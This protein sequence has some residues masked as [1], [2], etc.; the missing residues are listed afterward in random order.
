MTF[1]MLARDASLTTH[2]GT[3][4][5]VRPGSIAILETIIPSEPRVTHPVSRGRG[6]RARNDAPVIQSVA[7]STPLAQRIRGSLPS[8]SPGERKVALQVLT[9]YT[10]AAFAT[11][12]DLA[13]TAGTSGP[14]VMRF[15]T[16]LGFPG[17]RDFQHELRAEIEDRLRSPGARLAASGSVNARL[18]EV[19]DQHVDNL[20]HSYAAFRFDSA[21]RI[22]ALLGDERRTIWIFGGKYMHG[23]AYLLYAHLASLRARVSLLTDRPL[24][25]ADQAIDILPNDVVVVMD[26]R[27]YQRDALHLLDRARS[28]R[29]CS[30]ALTDTTNSPLTSLADESIVVAT[31][32]SSPFDSHVPAVSLVEAIVGMVSAVRAGRSA[33]R[34]AALESFSEEFDYFARPSA[35]EQ[36]RLDGAK[37]P[38]GRSV[39]GMAR[40]G[41]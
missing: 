36:R 6:S 4:D 29:A 17:F 39:R 13:A 18:D 40:S 5:T 23:V 25:L 7:F 9:A 28:V 38:R 37:S 19:L 8:M 2:R 11:V 16:R 35:K 33:A 15:A 12:S 31:S 34:L 1:A 14:T 3:D 41:T 10:H 26:F 20:R 24:P 30:I 27:R 21:Q 22:A 32:S